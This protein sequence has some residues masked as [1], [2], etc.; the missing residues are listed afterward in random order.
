MIHDF[1]RQ[2]EIPHVLYVLYIVE[3]NALQIHVGNLK[4]VLLVLT[5]HHDIGDTGT[6]GSQ[7]FLLDTAYG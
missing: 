2:H 3:G 5:T 1:L 4:N 7:D 6:L